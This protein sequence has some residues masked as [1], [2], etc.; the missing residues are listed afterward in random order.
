[1]AV[2]SVWSVWPLGEGWAGATIRQTVDGSEKLL[3]SEKKRLRWYFVKD[4]A[5]GTAPNVTK[6]RSELAGYTWGEV[7]SQYLRPRYDR[8][9]VGITW[10]DVRS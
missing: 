8:H 3:Y 4:S 7:A 6:V 1:M 9:F 5:K 2:V 10:H